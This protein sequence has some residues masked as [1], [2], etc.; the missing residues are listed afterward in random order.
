MKYNL[1]WM[2]LIFFS[3]PVI[4]QGAESVIPSL[5]AGASTQNKESPA[6]ADILRTIQTLRQQGRLEE[7]K[8]AAKIYLH[9]FP[10][11][12]DVQLLLGL[13]EMQQNNLAEAEFYL[14]QVL[15]NTPTYTDAR[16]AL[17][18]LKLRQ[19]RFAEANKLL[20]EGLRLQPGQAELL[21]LQNQLVKAETPV[22]SPQKVASMPAPSSASR[23][24]LKIQAPSAARTDDSKKLLA[25]LQQLRQQ[26]K[27]E[28]A[29]AKA[30]SYLSKNPDDGDVTLVLGLIYYQQ[31]QFAKASG[32]FKM[33][34]EKTPA[35][36]DARAALIRIQ[37][38][39]KKYED[40]RDL[41]QAGLRLNPGNHDLKEL[42]KNLAS[43]TAIKN[44][45]PVSP[46]PATV[47]P[48]DPELV[49]VNQLI[50]QKK[51]EKAKVYLIQLLEIHSENT[52]YRIALADLYLSQHNDMQALLLINKGLR[53]Q[54]RNIDLLLKKGEINTILREY[55]VAARV[56]QKVLMLSPDNRGARGMLN[57]IS[58]ISP[59]Y[60][61]G[62][63]EIGIAS[64]NAYVDDLHSI[65]D[66]STLYYSRDTDWGRL[67]G[68]INY[69]SR[70][71]L[72]ANQYEIDISPRFNRNIYADLMAAWS[73][74][75]ALFPDF[76]GA[77][78]GYV[79]IPKFFELSAGA[80][81]AQIAST[82]LS[83]YT[84]SFN[85][86]PGSLWL[87]FRPFYFV[88]R[89]SNS[90][91]YLYTGRVRKYF[92]TDDHYIGLGG[93]SGHSPDLADL[94]T[95]NFLVIKNSFIN[96]NY[97]FPIFNH[98]LVVDLSAG[99]QR[100]QYPSD[101]VRRLYDGSLGLRYRF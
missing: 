1:K 41:L 32:Y 69:A 16:V 83:T 45:K 71:S 31:Q 29:K 34:L 70:Q 37:L 73:D 9:Q 81:Y 66:W 77:A 79:N 55:A 82:Y 62:V 8:E 24:A 7:A 49:K 21:K 36:V 53:T 101:L 12:G 10:K 43:L 18:R 88:P 40:A 23:I 22:P 84:G 28:L 80:K 11:D 35:Y 60:T 64:D 6:E 27:L 51:Y 86:Y 2:I 76:T 97:T 58:S 94:L 100:W 74:Q 30:M 20:I 95:V 92:S 78:E 5:P 96:V 67:G 87:S 39:N 89:D 14:R 19:S 42:A 61:Y 99:Y 17:I 90:K 13:I 91:S 68:R 4:A 98:H 85:L 33:V 3:L 50:G 15:S 25:E 93:G 47:E 57:E 75:P 56:Y 26:G 46:A 65:W 44:K 48:I 63:N 52:R 38:I 54:P 72:N 59:R